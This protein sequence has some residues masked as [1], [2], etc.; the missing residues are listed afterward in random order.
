MSLLSGRKRQLGVEVSVKSSAA[1]HY[2]VI[3]NLLTIK[4]VMIYKESLQTNGLSKFDT[5][6]VPRKLKNEVLK[7]VHDGRMGGHFGCRKTEIKG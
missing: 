7:E 2:W 1:R 3:W 4:E 6:L 5:L